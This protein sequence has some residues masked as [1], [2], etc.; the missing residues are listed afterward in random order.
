MNRWDGGSL[1]FPR[2]CVVT[3]TRICIPT[4]ERGDEGALIHYSR[5]LLMII[6]MLLTVDAA[7]G[8]VDVRD[9]TLWENDKSYLLDAD[10]DYFPTD[11]VIEALKNGIPL[12][13]EVTVKVRESGSW[14]GWFGRALTKRKI[15]FQLRY[16]PLSSLYEISSDDNQNQRNF[17]SWKAL[18]ANL[19]ELRQIAIIEAGKLDA[20]KQ[21]HVAIKAALD[22]NSLPLPMRPMAYIDSDWDMSSGWSEWP[23]HQ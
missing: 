14:L 13:F 6:L 1:W 22:I 19:G 8:G 16:R 12:I 20:G 15:R 21:Y 18:F 4:Q 5:L 23:L 11:K 9:V 3:Q 10:V 7:A 2:S 17:V